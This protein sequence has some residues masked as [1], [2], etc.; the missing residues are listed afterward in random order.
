MVSV[1]SITITLLGHSQLT[2]S[3]AWGISHNEIAQ[4]ISIFSGLQSSGKV[5]NRTTSNRRTISDGIGDLILSNA[6]STSDTQISTTNSADDLSEADVVV[7]LPASLPFGFH[8]AH[9]LKST[10]LSHTRQIVP[11]ILE[12]LQDAIL[13]VATPFANHISAWI[14]QTQGLNNIIGIANG[15]STAHLKSEIAT[16]LG[17]SIKDVS[18]LAIGNDEETYPLPQYCRVNGIPILQLMDESELQNLAEVVTNHS[19]NPSVSEYTLASH[20]LQVVS[21]IALD[22]NRVMSAGT[23]ISSDTTSVFLNVP[24][25]I[26]SNGI[27]SII[28]L[29]LTDTQREHFKQLT[30]NS[31]S[32]QQFG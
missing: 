29:D 4:K 10:N 21:S 15:V 32:S 30:A 14:H 31:A 19:P 2:L 27:E 1:V 24:A 16:R 22:K 17:L 13:L 6:M 28:P 11:T 23:L 8:A 12:H 9:A 18:A 26:G 25:K 3:V 5:V 20:I 7:L